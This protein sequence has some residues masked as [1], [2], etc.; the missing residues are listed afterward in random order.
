MLFAGM[1]YELDESG[2]SVDLV[3]YTCSE[4]LTTSL[5]AHKPII[6]ILILN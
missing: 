3:L 2:L 6:L 4:K 1:G 5:Y